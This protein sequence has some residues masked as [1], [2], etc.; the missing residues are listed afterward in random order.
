MNTLLCAPIQSQ[1]QMQQSEFSS[2]E[3]SHEREHQNDQTVIYSDENQM[4]LTASHT[5]IIE[6][7]LLDCAKKEKSTKIDTTSFLASLKLHTEDARM[8]K[9]SNVSMD[10]NNSSEKKVDFNDFIKRLKM[11]KSYTS[12]FE[13]S[14]KENY[15][16]PICTK[17]S[18]NASSVHVSLNEEENGSDRTRI[19]REQDDGMNFTQCHTANIQNFVPVSSDATINEATGDGI[20]I[21]DNDCMDL[22]LNH[23]IQILPSAEDNLSKIEN[24]NQNVSMDATTL[25]G[26][27]ALG[28]KKVLRS[29]MNAAFKDSTLST[30]DK[31]IKSQMGAETHIVTQTCDQNVKN[32]AM[33]SESTSSTWTIDDH[34]TV[35]Y[36]T[37]SDAME[38]TRCVSSMLEGKS[39]PKHDDNNSK[40]CPSSN[41]ISLLTEKTFYSGN[42]GMDI[43]RSHTVAIDNNIFTHDQINVQIEAAPMSEKEMML[44][45]HTGDGN[46]NVNY[47]SIPDVAKECLQHSLGN[48]FSISLTD[49]KTDEDMDLTKCHTVNLGCQV[50]LAAN[51]LAPKDA[52]RF[53]SDES[54]RMNKNHIEPS[55]QLNVVSENILTTTWGKEKDKVSNISCYLEK[56]FPLLV[57]CN[58]NI[59]K[60]YKITSNRDLDKKVELEMNRNMVSGE[61]PF[62]ATKPSFSSERQVFLNTVVNSHIVV[63]GENA[64]LSEPLRKSLDSSTLNCS[65]D[66]MAVCGVEEENMD[67]TKNDTVTGFD[68]SEVQG[69]N[70]IKLEH[71]NGQLITVSK[72]ISV[73]VEKCKKK[74]VEKTGLFTSS[75]ME[76]EDKIV[77]QPGYLNEVQ[78]VK[79]FGRKSVGGQKNDK[80]IVFSDGDEN[81][82]DI[83]KSYTLEIKHKPSLG[84]DDSH[85]MFISGTSKTVLYT[86]GQDDMEI[87]RSHT[88][89]LDCKTASPAKISPRPLDKTVMFVDDVSDLDMTKAHTIFTDYQA[90][91]GTVLPVKPDFELPK[92]NSLQ[93]PKV[94]SISDE[95]NIF[96]PEDDENGHPA[97]KFSPL[98]IKVEG[99]NN[100][101]VERAEAFIGHE[102]MEM[103]KLMTWKDDKDKQKP[104][105]LNETQSGH[106]QRKKNLSLKNDKTILTLEGDENDMDITEGC[107]VEI[108]NKNV[109]EDQK[110]SHLMPEAESSKTVLYTCGQDDMEITRSHTSPLEY[111]IVSTDEMPPR[112]V[113]K[114]VMFVDDHNDL[115]VTRC[116]TVFTDCQTVEQS[117][118]KYP[119]FER[120]KE[121]NLGVSFPK[122]NSS[123][124][125]VTKKQALDIDKTIPLTEKQCHVIPFVPNVLPGG[126]SEVKITKFQSTA[127]NEEALKKVIDLDCTLRKDQTEN[128]HLNR[129]NV[130]FT[131]SHGMVTSGSSDSCLPNVICVVNMEENIMTLCDKEEEK[132]SNCTRQSDLTSEYYVKCEE[133]PIS[134]SSPLLEKG[135][136]TQVSNKEQLDYVLTQPQN[137]ENLVKEPHNLLANQ[138][139]REMNKFNF[140]LSN[141]QME[142]FIDNAEQNNLKM[143][144]VEVCVAS[145]P[146][147]S[148]VSSLPREGENIVNKE[149]IM[150][151]KTGHENLNSVPGITS[152]PACENVKNEREFTIAYKKELKKNIPTAKCGE[153]TDFCSSLH[154][155][156]IH[157]R[158]PSDGRIASD[159]PSY[160]NVKPNLNHLEEKTEDILDFPSH[161][162]PPPEQLPVL[163]NKVPNISIVHAT[164]K[165][166]TDI[167]SSNASADRNEENKNSHSGAEVNS[168]SSMKVVKDKNKVRKC[169][170]GI[171]LPRLPN[172][173]HYSVSGM[174][175]LEQISANITD[176]NHLETRPIC[177][178]DSGIEFVS[179]KLNLSPSQYINEENLP[180]CPEIN[181]SDSIS[182][183][184]EAKTLIETYQKEILPSENQAEEPCTSQKRTWVQDDDEDDTQNEKKVRKNEIGPCDHKDQ[185]QQISDCHPEGDIDKNVSS[186]LMKSL[187]RTP[188]SCSSSL[189]SI[190]A[191]GTS[192]DFSSKMSIKA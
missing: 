188:S 6:N 28:K 80:T 167:V 162:Q 134:T 68:P 90:N 71:T 26:T 7:D 136:I 89:P 44:Q 125:E 70:K 74:P 100:D 57:D 113:D 138:D 190:K 114:T 64:N 186:M 159:A 63:P 38:L 187:S 56:D 55:S 54:D 131:R 78:N 94:T 172:K 121:R 123:V 119:Q 110:D 128:C 42:D 185:D 23:T 91:E 112:P 33:I 133:L 31:I 192:L 62:S 168:E 103:S 142:D 19:F 101:P 5:L 161:V 129:R 15:E 40:M 35:F 174:D 4:D 132:A 181:S 117:L 137:Q 165:C 27:N 153:D 160:S 46:I 171:F 147:F 154:L 180:V 36:S 146:H 2:T 139:L 166:N 86:C 20:T 69:L 13:E 8:K 173:R 53:N 37:C 22:T 104:G 45:N 41:A 96:L 14:N 1:I 77:Q 151:S 124:Q 95:K 84:E 141:D 177:N 59:E 118:P 25:D 107:M 106:S 176:L 79:T 17:E 184:T 93:I 72:Q 49:R 43:T 157:A 126:Q 191:D 9:E 3:P 76:G 155:T 109:P 83:T 29:R 182:I 98:T 39:L 60:T 164:G 48:F 87:T 178:K 58:Q 148:T 24:Q 175:D 52:S 88:N 122:D 12:P 73:E 99:S 21:C 135:K 143:T 32:L 145:Q 30:E 183:E 47:G 169:S 75:N 81:D 92:V 105:F 150:F 11:G 51:N 50:P 66:K 111:K 115:E 179:T 10:Q 97:T 189:D 61:Q 65:H 18:T 152:L 158:E 108:N 34:K 127:V 102:N 130:D 67:L 144:F 116:H 16:P 120:T 149:Q 163:A 82:M 85:S 170:L 140:K 156:H